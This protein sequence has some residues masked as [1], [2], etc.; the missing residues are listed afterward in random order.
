MTM[1]LITFATDSDQDRFPL[2]GFND[3][4]ILFISFVVASKKLSRG[5]SLALSD[6][7]NTYHLIAHYETND[8]QKSQ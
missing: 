4:I 3:L 8:K 6:W 7:R 1:E 2:L 5:F